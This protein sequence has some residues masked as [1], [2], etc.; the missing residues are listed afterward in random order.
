MA[1]SVVMDSSS[2]EEETDEESEGVSFDSTAFAFC[3][4]PKESGLIPCSPKF[5]LCLLVLLC[6]RHV[7]L[8]TLSFFKYLNAHPWRLALICLRL[9]SALILLVDKSLIDHLKGVDHSKRSVQNLVEFVNSHR[10]ATII[11]RPL[12]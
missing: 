10:I 6:L 5:P 11:E 9:S 4:W 12:N 7:G 2:V 1:D 3:F 8:L